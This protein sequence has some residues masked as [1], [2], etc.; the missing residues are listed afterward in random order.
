MTYKRQKYQL[1][2]Q[3]KLYINFLP[4]CLN[5]S[6]VFKLLDEIQSTK[7]KI[8]KINQM[9]ISEAY[10]QVKLRTEIVNGLNHQPITSTKKVE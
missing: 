2:K 5:E 6:E 8:E 9:K 3:L 10:Q 4:F 1:S 7:L